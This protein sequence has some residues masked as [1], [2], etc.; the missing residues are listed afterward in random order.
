MT[1]FAN[2]P[3]NVVEVL[4]AA[5]RDHADRPY[6]I[7]GD[8][9]VTHAEAAA[10]AER[11]AAVLHGRHGVRRGD[12]LALVGANSVEHALTIWAVVLLGGIVVGLNGWWTGPELRHGLV[13]T[14]PRLLV[15]D[16]RR[17]ER[18]AGMPDAGL[19]VVAFDEL[20]ASAAVDAP[21]GVVGSRSSSARDGGADE[22]LFAG[23]IG[24]D[25]AIAVLFTSGTTGRAKGAVMSHRAV[26]NFGLDAGLRGAVD[27]VSG[28]APPPAGAAVSVLASPLFHISGLGPLLGAAPRS[29]MTL[30]LAP[31][32]R[33]DPAA[34]LELTRRYGVTQWTGVPTQ[35]LRLLEHPDLDPATL[36]TLRG[37][38]C[39]GAPMPPELPRV[40]AER[41]PG[42]RVGGGYGMTETFG[43]GT[44]IGGPRL[45]AHPGAVGVPTPT[46]ELM[47]RDADGAEITADGAVGEIWL[48]GPSVFL[49]Y[50]NDEGATAAVLDAD[51]WYRSGDYGRIVDGVVY[52]ESR[53]RDMIIRGGE[54]IYPIEIENRLI[55]HP[56]IAEA[57]V[58]GV[59]H[60]KLGQE[61]LAVLV[62]R[63]GTT[64]DPADVRDWVAATLAA[65]K[66]PS[67]VRVVDALPH[68]AS[69][70]V[71][72]H[73]LE[74][75]FATDADLPHH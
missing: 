32:G 55:E 37:I 72:K 60:E 65:F 27:V 75:R 20:A 73:D 39:G 74:V 71:I 25:E 21:A 41:L 1:V 12:R 54:N 23:D 57:A 14:D 48:R 50:W 38:G 9:T 11:V 49:G 16:E 61:V 17:L 63:D 18:I 66:V 47:L 51:G 68:N 31:P 2:R 52:L 10:V 56:D 29:G 3:R 62:P 7:L 15:G 36:V 13:L 4:R 33:W 26:V 59:P 70:K 30:V 40:V 53:L 5:G 45:V 46:S 8:R 24:E 64:L 43:M 69:G 44:A 28:A 35:F 22:S 34:H 6:L 19:P 67:R 58:I 42:V